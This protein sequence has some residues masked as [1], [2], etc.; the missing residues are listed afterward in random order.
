MRYFFNIADGQRVRDDI[1]QELP[2]HEA[3]QRYAV[4]VATEIL[5]DDPQ[6]IWEGHD[7]RVQ[8]TDDRGLL[9]FEV[10]TFSNFAPAGEAAASGRSPKG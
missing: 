3:A 8:V 9:L 1:G 6:F 5:Q 2:D 10:L 7:V 4:I